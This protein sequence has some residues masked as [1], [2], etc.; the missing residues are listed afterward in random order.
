LPDFQISTSIPTNLLKI[1][2]TLQAQNFNYST[3][4]IKPVP[5]KNTVTPNTSMMSKECMIKISSISQKKSTA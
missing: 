5:I 4:F 2:Q 1:H 3:K